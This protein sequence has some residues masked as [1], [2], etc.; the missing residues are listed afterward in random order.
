MVFRYRLRAR[1]SPHSAPLESHRPHPFTRSGRCIGSQH[2]LSFCIF[3]CLAKRIDQHIYPANHFAFL[4][5]P[6]A[7][8]RAHFTHWVRHWFAVHD[9]LVAHPLT[10][11]FTQCVDS[12]TTPR[13]IVIVRTTHAVLHGTIG[14]LLEGRNLCA[15][16]LLCTTKN[17]QKTRDGRIGYRRLLAP[18]TIEIEEKKRQPPGC[19]CA[20]GLRERKPVAQV[21]TT[22]RTPGARC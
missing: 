14:C 17:A 8:Q 4:L 15:R 2:T 10:H 21:G 3:M 22:G 20:E 9:A 11:R 6:N 16:R 19:P 7:R 18:S 1:C 12:D 13:R 5:A